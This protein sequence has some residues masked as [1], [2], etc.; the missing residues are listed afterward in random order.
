MRWTS[1]ELS[2]LGHTT[3]LT[4]FPKKTQNFYFSIS[5][6]H[7]KK[8]AYS[9]VC[10]LPPNNWQLNRKFKVRCALDKK[11]IH[12]YCVRCWTRV[13]WS[14][15]ECLS[16]HQFSHRHWAIFE[17]MK[18]RVKTPKAEERQ[19]KI[20]Q[21]S[22]A[23][24]HCW[25][26]CRRV[27]VIYVNFSQLARS[28]EWEGVAH[29]W[30]KYFV[31]FCHCQLSWSPSALWHYM[32]TLSSSIA[33]DNCVLRTNKQAIAAGGVRWHEKCIWVSFCCCLQFSL[34]CEW[35]GLFI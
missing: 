22:S 25:V 34:D 4:I 13:V 19:W 7:R 9:H 1:L 11:F 26:L 3:V 10:R 8:Q 16:W 24:L 30:G 21:I 23:L 31:I 6:K 27:V 14:A 28:I 12:Y 35:A 29:T 17:W 2:V 20:I 33:E 32:L 15:L 18:N 5:T